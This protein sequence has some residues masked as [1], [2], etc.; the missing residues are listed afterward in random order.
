MKV[1]LLLC[2]LLSMIVLNASDAEAEELHGEWKP[3]RAYYNVLS[4]QACAGDVDAYEELTTAAKQLG[5]AVA[6]ND[7]AW[8]YSTASCDFS[9]S[10]L[11]AAVELQRQSANAGYPIALSNYAVRLTEGIGTAR[12]ADAARVY[13]ERAIAAGYGTAAL[14]YAD[15]LLSAEYFPIDIEKVGQLYNFAQNSGA[16]SDHVQQLWVALSEAED[17]GT[18]RFFTDAWGVSD[19]EAHWDYVREGAL[20]S[21]V[22]FGRSEGDNSFYF[23]ILRNSHDPIVHV[24]GAWVEYSDG[25]SVSLG[26]GDCY[27]NH[28]LEQFYNDHSGPSSYLRVA[29]SGDE[30]RQTREML[31]SGNEVTFRYQTKTSVKS[32]TLFRDTMSLKGSRRAIEE[33]EAMVPK[34]GASAVSGRELGAGASS[35]AASLSDAAESSG[36]LRTGEAG[37]EASGRPVVTSYIGD[38]ENGDVLCTAEQTDDYPTYFYSELPST[39][40]G[41]YLNDPTQRT[42]PASTDYFK[43]AGTT[44]WQFTAD[45]TLVLY[46][47]GRALG[48][49]VDSSSGVTER[50]RG[51]WDITNRGI[52]INLKSPE[53]YSSSGH[54][55][56]ECRGGT[57]AASSAFSD[58]AGKMFRGCYILAICGSWF[59]NNPDNKRPDQVVMST[60]ETSPSRLAPGQ[61]RWI[62]EGLKGR[63]N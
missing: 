8:V 56:V 46:N 63:R 42:K 10:D 59:D 22:F 33:I 50:L 62:Q 12:D 37:S 13:F 7:L 39:T 54:K 29:L 34:A 57:L 28:C 41:A 58:G 48:L 5:N 23:G 43:G 47:D 32:E 51:A 15:Y 1:E 24:M 9:H 36:T 53:P 30:G 6:M 31:K 20:R 4:D 55:N 49:T 21:R 38:T 35:A 2:G 60:I 17:T 3:Q 16:D 18:E 44:V 19:D 11:E 27:A 61:M 25:T 14:L 40:Q 45:G 26:L 52:I